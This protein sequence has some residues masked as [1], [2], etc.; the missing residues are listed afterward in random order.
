LNKAQQI[1]Q[2]A[3]EQ[4]GV[5]V[6]STGF[7]GLQLSPAERRTACDRNKTP[8]RAETVAYRGEKSEAKE[9][10]TEGG[11]HSFSNN[12]EIQKPSRKASPSVLGH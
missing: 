7:L 2:D 10:R 5:R 8:G 3:F 12:T 11:V 1:L 9:K 4:L 6:I